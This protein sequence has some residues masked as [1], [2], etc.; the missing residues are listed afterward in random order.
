M[1]ISNGTVLKDGEEKEYF[2][3]EMIGRGG[4]GY[5]FKA[6]RLEDNQVF[7]VKTMLPAFSDETSI[8]SFKNEI[9]TAQTIEGEGVIKYVYT[10][11]GDTYPEFQAL[12]SGTNRF[13]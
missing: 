8:K 5:V 1:F 6:H 11:N 10:H 7:A 13:P 2:L 12:V 9:G 3:D 4:F